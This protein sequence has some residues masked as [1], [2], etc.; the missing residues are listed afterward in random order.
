MAAATGFAAT[1]CLSAVSGDGGDEDSYLGPPEDA[2]EDADYP[3]YGERVPDAELLGVLSG[4]YVTTEQDTEYLMTFSYTSCPTECLWMVSALVHT[5]RMIL[6]QGHEPPRVLVASFDPER[7]TPERMREYADRMGIDKDRGNWSMLRP[8]DKEE[9]EEVLGGDFGISFERRSTGEDSVYD[10]IHTTLILLV[11][12]DGYVE[13]TYTNDE[14]NPH[15]IA[16]DVSRL[17]EAQE[18]A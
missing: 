7:D 10:Y 15:L 11:N 5:E 13:R 17:R 4:E 9:A 8:E 6:E 12:E 14:P 3:T 18:T 2:H 1:G 16:D